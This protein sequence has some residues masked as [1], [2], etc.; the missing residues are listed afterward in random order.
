M[1]KK[2]GLTTVTLSMLLL[3]GCGGE[4]GNN[5]TTP[6]ITEQMKTKDSIIIYH[7]TNLAFC[8]VMKA[9]FSNSSVEDIKN[10]LTYHTN[11]NI[12]CNAY[13]RTTTTNL[14]SNGNCYELTLADLTD[15]DSSINLDDISIYEDPSN[16]CVIGADAK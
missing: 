15:F 2:L 6:T 12:G 14:N 8:E 1:I 4:S 3:S 9:Y 11:N 7:E 13:G 16:A 5:N 10:V